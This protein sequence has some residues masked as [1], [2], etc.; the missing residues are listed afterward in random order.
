MFFIK[1]TDKLLMCTLSFSKLLFSIVSIFLSSIIYA[2]TLPTL[3]ISIPTSFSRTET[4]YYVQ[5][6]NGNWIKVDRA[7]F[8][9]SPTETNTEAENIT[10]SI[11]GSDGSAT[12]LTFGASATSTALTA[13]DIQVNNNKGSTYEAS[14]FNFTGSNGTINAEAVNATGTNGEYTANGNRLNFSATADEAILNGD[15][16][17]INDN[18]GNALGFGTFTAVKNIDGTTVDATNA[19]GTNGNETVNVN[20]LHYNKTSESTIL[21]GVGVS[22]DNNSGTSLTFGNITSVKDTNGT[23][24]DATN[25]TGTDGNIDTSADTVN[26]NLTPEQIELGATGVSASTTNGNTLGFGTLNGVQND[27]GTNLSGTNATATFGNNDASADNV[28]AN[29]TPEQIEL[30]AT[31]VSVNTANGNTLGFGTLNGVQNNDGTNLNG[32]NATAV[33]GNIDAS[34]DTVNANL[35]PEQIELGATGV[36]AS[37]TNGNTLGFG[38]L[39]GVQNDDG[40]T[41]NTTNVNG[42]FDGVIT[43]SET[44]RYQENLTNGQTTISGT[45]TEIIDTNGKGNPRVR[46]NTFDATTFSGRSGTDINV[47]GTFQRTNTAQPL[48]FSAEIEKLESASYNRVENGGTL[49]IQTSED[50]G[51]SSTS[52]KLGDSISFEAT[53]SDNNATQLTASYFFDKE[54]GKLS[55]EIVYKNGDEV[56]IKVLPFTFTSEQDLNDTAARLQLSASV[57][58]QD[59]QAYLATV[60]GLNN[61]DYINDYL[62]VGNGKMRVRIGGSSGLEMIYSNPALFADRGLASPTDE[63]LALGVGIFNRRQ[64]GSESS[65]GLLLSADSSLS[66]EIGSGS[67]S[68]AGVPLPDRGEIPLTLGLYASHT[69]SD[70]TTIFGHLGTSVKDFESFSYSAAVGVSTEIGENTTLDVGAAYNDQGDFALSAMVGIEL[71]QKPAGLSDEQRGVYGRLTKAERAAAFARPVRGISQ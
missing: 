31:D 2:Q 61:F 29:L 55:M 28:N 16:T 51:I 59:I 60:A 17:H 62:A 54:A 44:L 32:T 8:S 68:V 43:T 7:K 69:Y 25:A 3:P 53:D 24:I 57:N 38:T 11:N 4:D 15:N 49:N 39:N 71:N 18:S 30:G 22:A 14:Q 40:T 47:D 70:G 37:T 41:I 66:Y 27:N 12:R 33:F 19:I 13:T 34:A 42:N 20:Q 63:K 21:S 10:G 1:Y 67:L 65:L 64:D 6:D 58:P 52:V 5:D 36:S 26:A 46:L 23:A 50:G 48:Q 9:Y 56:E 45:N 35:T